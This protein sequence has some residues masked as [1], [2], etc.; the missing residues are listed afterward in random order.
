MRIILELIQKDCFWKGLYSLAPF[1]LSLSLLTAV[2]E[3]SRCICVVEF[4]WELLL[5]EHGKPSSILQIIKFHP[6]FQQTKTLLKCHTLCYVMFSE[7]VLLFAG[8]LW[9]RK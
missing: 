4:E 7:N 6:M 9:S 5:I 2:L 1:N 8:G 3:Y